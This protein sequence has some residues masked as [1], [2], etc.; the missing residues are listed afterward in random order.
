MGQSYQ[1]NFK[2]DETD[3]YQEE[4]DKNESEQNSDSDQETP[5][6]NGILS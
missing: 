1:T 4:I 6:E 3:I 2:N 5:N